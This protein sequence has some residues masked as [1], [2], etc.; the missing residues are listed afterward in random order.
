MPT[1]FLRCRMR[2]LPARNARAPALADRRNRPRRRGEGL[3]RSISRR[4]RPHRLRRRRGHRHPRRR[5]A[6]ARSATAAWSWP[7]LVDIHTHLDKGQIWPRRPNPDGTFTGALENVGADRE[8]RWTATTSRPD[9]FRCAAPS[10]TAPARSAPI[11]TPSASDRDLLA[12]LRRDARGLAGPDRAAGRGAVPDGPGARRAG[13][14]P[15]GR[16]DQGPP[17][18][19]ARRRHLHG[20]TRRTPAPTPRSTA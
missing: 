6:R 12:G 10:R 7:R 13:R 15:R 17:W 3:A 5:P 1:G 11:S 16:R 8:A 4:G 9:G 2:R 14:V 19:R 20:P 18:R